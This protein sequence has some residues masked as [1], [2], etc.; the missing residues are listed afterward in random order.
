MTGSGSRAARPG[1]R[2]VR[3]ALACALVA[4]VAV[5]AVIGLSAGGSSKVAAVTAE[6]RGAARGSAGAAGSAHAAAPTHIP[7]GAYGYIPSWLPQSKVPVSR[8]VTATPAHPWLAIQGDTVKV[9]LGHVQV[10]ATASGP[11][12]PEIGHFPL[13]RTSFCRFTITFADASGVI[14]LN[15]ADFATIDEV[16]RLHSLR[17][18]RMGG[19][20]VPDEVR[21][22]QTVSLLASVVLPTG[23]GRFM[24]APVAGRPVVQWDFD[25]EID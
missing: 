16:G 13:P 12:V 10:L 7:A 23:E 6:P 5:L 25:V 17:V 24:W 8:V 1:S 14:A 18:T 3:A 2:A 11:W 4:A 21:P 15:R 19:G 22:G 20:S 9:V